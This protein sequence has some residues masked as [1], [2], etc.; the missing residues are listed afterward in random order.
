MPRFRSNANIF[1]HLN[2]EFDPNWMDSKEL[3]V[4]ATKKWTY[5][6]EMNIDDVDL[7]EVIY[8]EGGGKGV[9]AS[10][11]PYAEFYLICTGHIPN[12]R[13][14]RWETYYGPGAEIEVRKR[15]KELN[16]PYPVN[17]V[18]VDNEDMWLH[19]PKL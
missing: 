7:W 16:W 8:E 6:R 13:T 15:M 3:V 17:Q 10:Y 2:E 11:L 19:P 9:Y 1:V 12:G 4:P 14:P 18:W 5:D